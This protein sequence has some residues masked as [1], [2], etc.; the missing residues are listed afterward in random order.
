MNHPKRSNSVRG[1]STTGLV[2][3]VAVGV[4][5]AGCTEYEDDPTREEP[6]SPPAGTPAFT[7]PTPGSTSARTT[8]QAYDRLE[9]RIADYQQ[10]VIEEAE[11]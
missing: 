8:K 10:K 5:L 9:Q 2:V 7:D 11:K 1:V 4:L 3:A 6:S